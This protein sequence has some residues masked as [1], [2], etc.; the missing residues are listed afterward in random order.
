MTRHQALHTERR[1]FVCDQCGAAFHAHTTLKDHCTSVHSEQRQFSCVTCSKTFK[2]QSDLRRHI[3]SHSDTHPFKCQSCSQAYKRASHLRRHEKATH[4]TVFKPRKLQRLEHD[5]NGVLVPVVEDTRSSGNG[6]RDEKAD[7]GTAEEQQLAEPQWSAPISSQNSVFTGPVLSL[8]DADSGKVITLQELCADAQIL[9]TTANLSTTGI[10]SLPTD[11]QLTAIVSC[12]ETTLDTFQAG[13][14]MQAIEVTYD[15]SFTS[16]QTLTTVFSNSEPRLVFATPIAMSLDQNQTVLAVSSDGLDGKVQ[17]LETD[18]SKLSGTIFIEDGKLESLEEP[19]LLESTEPAP[20]ITIENFTALQTDGT[21]LDSMLHLP[22]EVLSSGSL[23]RSRLISGPKMNEVPLP[24]LSHCDTMSSLALANAV[25]S[26]GSTLPVN[27]STLSVSPTVPAT[28]VDISE[29]SN[30]ISIPDSSYSGMTLNHDSTITTLSVA[31]PI[32]PSPSAEKCSGSPLHI[33][34]PGPEMLEGKDSNGNIPSISIVDP[35]E[36]SGLDEE[37]RTTTT[38][39][40]LPV[41]EGCPESDDK[42]AISMLSVDALDVSIS[43]EDIHPSCTISIQ[44]QEGSA[45]LV[46]ASLDMHPDPSLSQTDEAAV[47]SANL[48]AEFLPQNFPFLN[49]E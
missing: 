34:L 41:E 19:M 18:I 5:E 1:R 3:R 49:V 6:S 39:S 21:E 32:V 45:D 23:L 22:D 35:L 37:E 48:M 16:P 46:L 4:G 13:N 47:A 20:H 38:L 36:S 33:D 17:L 15:L 8:V 2:L 29:A 42:T 40:T 24:T 26:N 43:G 12:P 44:P 11:D 30:L 28:S 7:V 27:I 14:V 31:N 9:T 25:E 10:L